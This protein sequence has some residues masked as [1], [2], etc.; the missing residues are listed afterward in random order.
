[1][2]F[3]SIVRTIYKTLLPNVVRKALYRNMP[4]SLKLM[5]RSV[6]RKL[7]K[8]AKHD[9]IY[10]EKYYTDG[11]DP[12]QYIKSCEVIAKSIMKVFSPKSVV[13]VGCGRGRLL[14]AIKKWG[15]ACRGLEY[16]SAALNFCSRN[17]LDVIRF[18]LR[19][20]MLPKDF[21]AD[22]VISTEVAEHLPEHCADRFVDILCS[23]S[24]NVV[25]TAAEP[26]IT[27][28]GDHTHVNEQP[29]KYWIEKFANKSFAYN[30]DI[31]TQFCKDW[32]EHKIKPWFYRHLMVLCKKPCSRP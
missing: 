1:M 7:E 4:K 26:A 25:M 22:V 31:V 5:K 23:I 20:D 10:D 24:D 16:S 3:Y 17:G 9:D 19:H 18:D 2:S 8:S 30:E 32:Q 29:K 13:D 15:I 14:S 6:I 28:V 12:Q 21:K 11:T 27:Y